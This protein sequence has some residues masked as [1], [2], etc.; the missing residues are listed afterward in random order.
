[1]SDARAGDAPGA[2]PEAP[3]AGAPA[4][5]PAKRGRGQRKIRD[6]PISRPAVSRTPSNAQPQ[7]RPGRR[8]SAKPRPP[9]TAPGDKPPHKRSRKPRSKVRA[10]TPS[11][12]GAP[13]KYIKAYDERGGVGTI[14]ELRVV[15]PR[16]TTLPAVFVSQSQLQ[17]EPQQ[18]QAK[19]GDRTNAAVIRL[20]PQPASVT[21]VGKETPRACCGGLLGTPPSRNLRGFSAGRHQ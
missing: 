13:S 12:G 8:Q 14:Y 5:P 15:L 16:G 10:R 6:K 3:A 17:P 2:R 20:I 7:R 4:P 9:R 19:S 11:E 21:V 1:M 18:R